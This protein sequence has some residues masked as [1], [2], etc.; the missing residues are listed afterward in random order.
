MFMKH[1]QTGEAMIK[2]L[3]C[4]I[5]WRKFYF[6]KKLQGRNG[7]TFGEAAHEKRNLKTRRA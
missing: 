4:R 2:D 6:F 1:V 7:Y 3:D 5:R